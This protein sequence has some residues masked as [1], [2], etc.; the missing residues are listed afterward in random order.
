[1]LQNKDTLIRRLQEEVEEL[2]EKQS[3]DEKEKMQELLKSYQQ[4]I[5]E[6]R[7]RASKPSY[8]PIN[9]SQLTEWNTFKYDR[10]FRSSNKEMHPQSPL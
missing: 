10:N 2:K 4:E 1:M 3:C 8:S 5:S 9:R 7:G 6:L